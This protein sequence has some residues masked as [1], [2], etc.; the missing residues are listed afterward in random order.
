MN[1]SQ[2][3]DLL[4]TC[5]GDELMSLDVRG[6]GA[7]VLL[8]GMNLSRVTHLT[9]EHLRYRGQQ[10]YL[11]IGRQPVLLP[12]RLAQVLEQLSP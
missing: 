3:W 4:R 2:R 1:E 7:L 12:P 9:N 5:L 8:Y 10:A 11:T 6:A